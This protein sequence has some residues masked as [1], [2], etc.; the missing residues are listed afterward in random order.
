M[1]LNEMQKEHEHSL[2]QDAT[3]AAQAKVIEDLKTQM[4]ELN[5]LTQELRAAQRH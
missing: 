1:L 5:D 3:I 4:S 2:M